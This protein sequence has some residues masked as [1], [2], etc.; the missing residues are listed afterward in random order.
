MPLTIPKGNVGYDQYAVP[1]TV[2]VEPTFLASLQHSRTHTSTASCAILLNFFAEVSSKPHIKPI[3]MVRALFPTTFLEIAVY[4]TKLRAMA[5][6]LR[7]RTV[8]SHLQSQCFALIRAHHHG[9]VVKPL[10][11]QKAVLRCP[12]LQRRLQSL[13]MCAYLLTLV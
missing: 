9:M 8:I 3:G 10:Y 7:M 13:V 5:S 1:D 6:S 4:V 2:A 11:H 12:L